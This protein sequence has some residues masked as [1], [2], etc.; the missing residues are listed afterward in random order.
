MTGALRGTRALVTG[1][2]SGIG[3]ATAR[4]FCEEGARV[5]LVDRDADGV[6]AARFGA[7]TSGQALLYAADGRLLFHGGL[8]PSRGHEGDNEGLRRVTAILDG[9]A[10]R[11]ES[12]VFGCSLRD[13][14]EV[15]K[16]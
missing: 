3:K 8:T 13:A 6:E 12:P 16:R 5:V 9:K 2:A 15:A 10:A 11:D 7:K 14:D 4:R 1:A